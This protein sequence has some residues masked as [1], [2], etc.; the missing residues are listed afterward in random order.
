[1]NVINLIQLEKSKMRGFI[2]KTTSSILAVCSI[3][4]VDRT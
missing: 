1:M 4:V 2:I 3:D